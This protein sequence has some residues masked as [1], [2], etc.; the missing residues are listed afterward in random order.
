MKNKFFNISSVAVVWASE[1]EGKLGNELLKMLSNFPGNKY[2]VNPKWGNFNGI[3]FYKSITDL[4]EVVDALVF[5]TPAPFIEESLLETAKRWIKRAIVITAGFKDEGNIEEEERIKRIAL[6]N[7]ILLLGP[8]CLWHCDPQR[9]LNLSFWTKEFLKWNISIVSQSG[10][11]AVVTTDWALEKKLGFSK[12]VSIGNRTV[13]DEVDILNEL[14]DDKD[15]KV[16]ALYL[17]SI[18]RLP[19]F[20]EL[21]KNIW[22][23]VILM[24]SW[25][26]NEE[27]LKNIWV[28]IAYNLEEFFALIELFSKVEL[29]SVPKDLAIITNTSGLGTLATDAVKKYWV[30]LTEFSEEEKEILKKDLPIISVWNPIDILW[31][32][33]SKSYKQILENIKLLPK[34]RAYLILVSPQSITDVEN[35]AGAIADFKEKNPSIFLFTSFVWGFSVREGIN[36]LEENGIL[37][38]FEP[39]KAIKCFQIWLK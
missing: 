9:D 23:K 16:I 4:P 17:K 30:T 13:L 3:E 14:K 10:A 20:L 35:I 28:S 39:E 11:I 18:N 37:N 6:E 25:N 31:D 29:E 34:R 19:L 5:V 33:T 1:K 7:D 32:A 22:K 21:V 36:I 38:Y 2:G 24:K 12:V 8:N 27:E 15:T 26:Q